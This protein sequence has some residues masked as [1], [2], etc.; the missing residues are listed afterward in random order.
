[1]R[2]KE[3]VEKDIVNLAREIRNDDYYGVTSHDELSSLFDELDNIEKAIHWKDAPVNKR[4]EWLNREPKQDGG[5]VVGVAV[6]NDSTVYDSVDSKTLY[7]PWK[8]V[9]MWLDEE[10]GKVRVFNNNDYIVI[11]E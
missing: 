11:I 9:K 6:F 4:F 1:M 2:T 3:D 10:T 8:E 5:V 7:S